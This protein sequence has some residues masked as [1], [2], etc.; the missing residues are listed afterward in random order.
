MNS[1]L[2]WNSVDDCIYSIVY[3][4]KDVYI[5][6][7]YGSGVKKTPPKLN[8]QNIMYNILKHSLASYRFIAFF[9]W[10]LGEGG[11]GLS[12]VWLPSQ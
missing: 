8:E 11:G 9:M 4:G 5:F 7:P 1:Q 6:C 2:W 10:D 3:Q 12:L